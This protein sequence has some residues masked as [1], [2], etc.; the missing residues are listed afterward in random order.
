MIKTKAAGQSERG[1]KRREQGPF[2]GTS[3]GSTWP[4]PQLLSFWDLKGRHC[5]FDLEVLV[6]AQHSVPEE[7]EVDGG[8]FGLDESPEAPEEVRGQGELVDLYVERL[9]LSLADLL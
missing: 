7:V 1:Q 9:Q 5:W 4:P 6:E 2:H 3:P 8:V